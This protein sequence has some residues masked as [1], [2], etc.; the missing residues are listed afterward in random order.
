MAVCFKAR[1]A[2]ETEF[3]TFRAVSYIVRRAMMPPHASKQKRAGAE[4]SNP[5]RMFPRVP[6]RTQNSYRNPNC[7]TRRSP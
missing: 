3:T 6:A 5:R 4:S 7:I 2:R 1:S